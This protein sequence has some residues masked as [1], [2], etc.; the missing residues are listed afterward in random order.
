MS[1]SHARRLS[2]LEAAAGG[3]VVCRPWR[4]PV[5]VAV[6]RAEEAAADPLPARPD[7]CP[8]CDRAVPRPLTRIV[9]ARVSHDAPA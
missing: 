2:A 9:I 6:M 7:I 4:E 5:R 1:R 8:R 3:C